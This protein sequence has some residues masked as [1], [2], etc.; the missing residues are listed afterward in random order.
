VGYIEDVDVLIHD[1]IKFG[2]SFHSY[3]QLLLNPSMS[4]NKKKLSDICGKCAGHCLKIRN[5]IIEN[6][7]E[8]ETNG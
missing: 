7:K 5:L 1:L 6:Q 2:Q 8:E 3:A 4:I